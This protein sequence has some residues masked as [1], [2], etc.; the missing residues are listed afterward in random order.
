MT[1]SQF[2]R[3]LLRLSFLAFV[4]SACAQEAHRESKSER[5][6]RMQWW[7][8]ARFGM[9]IHWGVYSV[10]ARGE[11]VMYNEKIPVSEYEKFPPQFNPVKFDATEWVRIA[12]EGG[13]KYI[14]ITSKHHDGF[15]MWDSKVT[16][17][18]I[19][20]ATPFKRD[21]LKELADA[22][23]KE[24][25]RLCF[26]HSIMDWHHP[27]AKGDRFPVYR[28][29]Y[30]KPQL[31]ELL[32]KYGPLG[33]LW[34]DGQRIAEWD[35]DQGRELYKELRALQPDLIINNRIGKGRNELLDVSNGPAAAMV[36]DFGTPEQYIPGEASEVFDWESCMTMND[37]W[38]Y[39]VK[40]TNWKTARTL[41]RNLV[42][43]A[44]KGGNYLLNVGPTAEGLIPSESVTRLKEIG[45]WLKVN[46][47]AIYGTTASPFESTPW[48]RCT[49]RKQ[50]DGKTT[51]Y[52]HVFDWPKN[53][54]L[55]VAGLGSDPLRTSLLSDPSGRLQVGRDLDTIIISLPSQ[56][57]D[58]LDPV[59]AL[60]FNGTVLAY[61]RPTVTS[62]A[63]MFLD[64]I[65]VTMSVPIQ[66]LEIR[67]AL[68]GAI[69]TKDS[70]KYATPIQFDRST[71]LKAQTFH[72][73]KP[74]SAIVERSYAKV[75]PQ[76][77][78]SVAGLVP[79]LN[80]NCYEGDWKQL[81]DFDRLTP[82]K[83]GVAKV[84]GTDFRTRQ[85]RY[86]LR[87]TGYISVPDDAVYLFSLNSDDGSKLFIDGKLVVDNDG[88]HSAVD[89]QAFVPLA[90]GAHAIVV[91]YFN[92]GWEGEL[93][94]RMGVAGRTLEA[95]DARQLGRTP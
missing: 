20:D 68:D 57:P 43:I 37:H 35:E 74:V 79:G 42:D 71:V 16:A 4:F 7:R 86:G 75:A 58:S 88:L 85:E 59:L 29:N 11:W 53:G 92:G 1:I 22:C 70:P 10:P 44:S 18:D 27:D 34:F 80:C 36:G 41:V 24:G 19:M 39:A 83:S 91:A 87:F 13:V 40:D 2:T 54:R 38:G 81:P 23:K 66:E 69:P 61:R 15:C 55:R 46:G 5:D 67:Y 50:S 93:G 82:V 45:A 17:Y 12:K 47:E 6:A 25:I 30:L 3:L 77:A 64:T 32:A 89:K 31:K 9:F 63:P 65:R 76:P 48:G 90:K 72:S 26:Y 21:V 60:E 84:I 78:A 95:L 94:V 62:P 49:T 52:L 73:G 33:V 8:E 28:D 14:V 51:L 56:S